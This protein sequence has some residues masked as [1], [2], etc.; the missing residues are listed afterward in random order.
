MENMERFMPIHIW[1]HHE[2]Y[3]EFTLG[4]ENYFNVLIFYTGYF[5]KGIENIFSCV[6]I[7]SPALISTGI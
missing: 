3:G 4:K 2:Q 7:P 5:I 6:L 1:H